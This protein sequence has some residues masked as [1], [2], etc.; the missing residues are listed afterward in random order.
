MTGHGNLNT[1]AIFTRLTRQDITF[2]GLY[3][4]SSLSRLYTIHNGNTAANSSQSIRAAQRLAALIPLEDSIPT[5]SER[6]DAE[7]C[8]S[9]TLTR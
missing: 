3:F 7:E 1:H 6:G 4:L 9:E 8:L 5:K 2:C